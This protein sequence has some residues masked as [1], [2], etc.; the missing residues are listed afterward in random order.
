MLKNILYVGMGGFLG[1]TSRYIIS[2]YLNT[3]F[4]YG[5]LL[6]NTLGSLLLGFLAFKLVKSTDVKPEIILMM[7]TGFIGAFTT[8]SSYMLETHLLWSEE[9]LILS[10]VYLFA[11]LF[12]GLVFV[13]IGIHLGKTI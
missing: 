7:T 11:N 3:D 6:V 13:S 2:H 8:F 5:T 12:L 1:S 10:I 4:P 9:R